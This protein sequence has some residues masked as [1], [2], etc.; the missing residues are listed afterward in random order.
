MS[1]DR[2]DYYDSN[3]NHIGY[4]QTHT[5]SISD[6]ELPVFIVMAAIISVIIAIPIGIIGGIGAA[7]G[8]L[9]WYGVVCGVFYGIGALIG[10]GLGELSNWITGRS[11]QHNDTYVKDALLDDGGY[12]DGSQNIY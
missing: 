3:G 5:S 7:L 1:E 9:F 10:W 6:I 2:R 11:R 12:I 4:S 8:F